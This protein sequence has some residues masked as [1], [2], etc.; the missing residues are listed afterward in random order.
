[1]SDY[2]NIIDYLDE[3]NKAFYYDN[4][5]YA[6][7]VIV[8]A[9]TVIPLH[10]QK[11]KFLANRK[12][13]LYFDNYRIKLNTNQIRDLLKVKWNDRTK[14]FKRY[15]KNDDLEMISTVPSAPT[16]TP[17]PDTDTE[18]ET[19][20]ETKTAPESFTLLDYTQQFDK[21]GAWLSSPVGLQ[22]S[23]PDLHKDRIK[24]MLIDNNSSW[25]MEYFLMI[26]GI[27]ASLY[28]LRFLIKE[29][30]DWKFQTDEETA[31]TKTIDLI[32]AGPGVLALLFYLDQDYRIPELI[33]SNINWK[34]MYGMLV[35]L[36]LV[37]HILFRYIDNRT[38]SKSN[39][40]KNTQFIVGIVFLFGLWMVIKE[41]VSFIDENFTVTPSVIQYEEDEKTIQDLIDEQTRLN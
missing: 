11:K 23:H 8:V 5:V 35:G 40:F 27:L 31:V 9:A 1:M 7:V 28:L 2:K 24:Y 36:L 37:G 14:L 13:W 17:A 12:Y 4:R 19:K 21:G 25:Y 34:I 10:T 33:N 32:V 15:L 22:E 41:K 39:N 6:F 18:T 38:G 26:S 29:I 3:H 16:P 30:A 20:T